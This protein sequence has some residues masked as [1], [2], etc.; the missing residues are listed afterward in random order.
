MG[1]KSASEPI[2]GSGSLP[3]KV[4]ID[5]CK[6]PQS[7]KRPCSSVRGRGKERE[8]SQSELEWD[9]DD[10]E[11]RNEFACQIHLTF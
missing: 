9:D 1:T 8:G 10:G 11:E 3:P 6:M 4:T 7:E 2:C 5:T